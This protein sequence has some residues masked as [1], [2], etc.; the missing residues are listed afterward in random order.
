AA[1]QMKMTLP[2]I[3]ELLTCTSQLHSRVLETL[4]H[5]DDADGS[6]RDLCVPLFMAIGKRL[7]GINVV[8]LGRKHPL[9]V[10]E[11]RKLCER[12]ADLNEVVPSLW[13]KIR[14]IQVSQTQV[15]RAQQVGD[16]SISDSLSIASKR[17]PPRK[18][19]KHAAELNNPD[20]R[21][22]YIPAQFRGWKGK[23]QQQRHLLVSKVA[24]RQR[25]G[26]LRIRKGYMKDVERKYTKTTYQ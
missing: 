11:L 13:E 8:D 1:Q 9:L 12:S 3:T 14:C 16:R 6:L 23:K 7:E 15:R 21:D 25:F 5:H 17:R 22:R 20:Y 19:D 26:T 10:V 24:S 18:N 4:D 2:Q